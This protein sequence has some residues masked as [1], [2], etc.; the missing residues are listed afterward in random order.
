[1]KKRIVICEKGKISTEFRVQC[2][3]IRRVRV[4]VLKVI[5]VLVTV[6]RIRR[7]VRCYRL[8]EEFEKPKKRLI[9]LW[10]RLT[11]RIRWILFS[12][13]KR[14]TRCLRVD[15]GEEEVIVGHR[16]IRKLRCPPLLYWFRVCRSQ[17]RNRLQ[18]TVFRIW[19]TTMTHYQLLVVDNDS[20][21]LYEVSDIT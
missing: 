17:I 14:Y 19:I 5:R 2:G 7:A 12:M 1:M 16:V 6:L 18:C 9:H 4:T 8:C 3:F 21:R 10:N 13:M 20:P 15:V 11:R